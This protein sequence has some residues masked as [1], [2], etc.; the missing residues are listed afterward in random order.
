[1]NALAG[2]WGMWRAVAVSFDGAWVFAAVL[3]PLLVANAIGVVLRREHVDRRISHGLAMAMRVLGGLALVV[4]AMAMRAELEGAW[5]VMGVA[6]LVG[7]WGVAYDHAL[8]RH[9]D[10]FARA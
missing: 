7:L 8:Q 5:T 4:G 9:D 3:S 10:A 1:V 2:A 6:A